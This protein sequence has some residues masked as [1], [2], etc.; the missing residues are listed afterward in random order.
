MSNSR[1]VA[2]RPKKYS[3]AAFRK[4]VNRYFSS[5]SREKALKEKVC[6]GTDDGGKDIY[7]WQPIRNALGEEATAIEY[8]QKPS[9]SGLCGF[10]HIHR[11]TFNE[12]SRHEDYADICDAV[13]NEI[14]AYLCS[15]LGSGK[16]D[17]GIIFNL[18]HNFGWKNKI[19]VETGEETRKSM[20]KMAMTT[21]EKISWLLA[22]GYNIP[23]LE[24][25]KED[26]G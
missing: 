4:G 6:I 23:G 14:E 11:D 24:G 25:E 16:G 13:K 1:N 5:I 26:G 8:F 9:V 20:E 15:Q 3:P 22:H 12:Y 10:L 7:Q 17:S 18:T 2:G 19:E 21:D